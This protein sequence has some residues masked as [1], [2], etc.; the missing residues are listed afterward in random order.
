MMKRRLENEKVRVKNVKVFEK[1]MKKC[2]NESFM[3]GRRIWKIENWGKERVF[4][5]VNKEDNERNVEKG[6]FV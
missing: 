6:R 5:G 4:F 1:I 2:K 3:M